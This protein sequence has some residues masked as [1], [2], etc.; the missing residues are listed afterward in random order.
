MIPGDLYLA[1]FFLAFPTFVSAEPLAGSKDVILYFHHDTTAMDYPV[2]FS[3]DTD[4]SRSVFETLKPG[5]QASIEGIVKIDKRG[6]VVLR[7]KKIITSAA[8]NRVA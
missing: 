5:V 8:V 7:A 6:A 3:L 2:Y 1:K 4:V